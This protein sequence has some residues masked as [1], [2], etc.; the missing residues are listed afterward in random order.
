MSRY[1]DDPYLINGLKFDLRIYVLVTCYDPLRVY[2][3]KEG[4]ARFAT[5][6]YNKNASK[7]NRYMHLTNYSINKKSKKFEKIATHLAHIRIG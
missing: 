4:L 1:I 6:E 2:V 3:F 7:E 5:E